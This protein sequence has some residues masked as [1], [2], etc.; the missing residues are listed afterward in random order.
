M[1]GHPDTE[2]ADTAAVDLIAGH[3][4]GRLAA[5]VDPHLVATRVVELLRDAGW[6]PIPRPEQ[7]TASGP[8]DPTVAARGAERVREALAEARNPKEDPR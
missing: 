4:A 3:L 6:R 5:H 2:R 1:T 8:R 7:I